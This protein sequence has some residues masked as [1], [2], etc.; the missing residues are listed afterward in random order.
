MP[1]FLRYQIETLS[2]G[3]P[4]TDT[5]PVALVS[6]DSEVSAHVYIVPPSTNCV[7]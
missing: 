4:T 5:Q 2:D 3:K 6:A 7:I 1:Q